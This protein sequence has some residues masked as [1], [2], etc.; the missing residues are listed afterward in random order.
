M[1]PL[2]H[3]VLKWCVGCHRR[4][5]NLY[6]GLLKKLEISGNKGTVTLEDE[7]IIRWE[8]DPELPEDAKTRER[9]AETRW[10]GAVRQIPAPSVTKITV[11]KWPKLHQRHRKRDATSRRWTRGSQSGRDYP[12]H[13]QIQPRRTDVERTPLILTATCHRS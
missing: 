11:C 1:S 12:R 3:S 9:F 7:D 2:Q 8:F 6:P 5:H 10:G 13:L 4:H